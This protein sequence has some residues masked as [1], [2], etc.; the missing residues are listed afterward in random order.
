MNDDNNYTHKYYAQFYHQITMMLY[1]QDHNILMLN[2][3]FSTRKYYFGF[4]I[5]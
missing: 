5:K 1:L 2:E 4:I 3:E